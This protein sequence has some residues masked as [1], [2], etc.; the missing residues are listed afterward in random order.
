MENSTFQPSRGRDP[1]L[2]EIA[3]RRV[4][5]KNHIVSYILVISFLWGV[6]YFSGSHWNGNEHHY[7]WPIWP[8]IGWG[9]GLLF[10]YLG[11]YVYPRENSVEQEYEK[12][13]RTKK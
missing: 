12:L 4:C 10:H 5:F 7:P 6:W 8:T 13:I 3:K 11:A 9:I 2:W 1:Q